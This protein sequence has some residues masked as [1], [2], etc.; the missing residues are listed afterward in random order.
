MGNTPENWPGLDAERDGVT[1]SAQKI[2]SVASAL[3]E[4]LKPF[5]GQGTDGR[6]SVEDLTSYGGVNQ[7]RTQLQTIS[8][9]EGGRLF[10]ESLGRSH[11]EFLDVYRRVIINFQ[12]AIALIETGA[13]VYGTT[14]T[15]N[16]G[17]V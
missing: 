8:N 11:Q 10:S 13:G 1:Y 5:E 14:N 2:K 6:G 16:E 17:E 15:A 4:E 7:L 9:W 12:T 3:R